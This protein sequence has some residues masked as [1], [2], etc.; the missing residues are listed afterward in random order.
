MIRRPPRSTLFPYTTLFRSK[1][2]QTIDDEYLFGISPTRQLY[3]AWQTTGGGA[4]GTPSFNDVSGTGQIPLNT[5]AHI[6][7]VR[8]GAPLNFSIN[9]VLDASL[10]VV[11]TNPFR[12]G[13]NTL[14]IGGQGRGGVNRFFNGSIDEV[15]I[16]TRALTQAE[17]QND[18][19]S[20]IGVTPPPSDTTPPTVSITAPVTGAIVSGGVTVSANATDNVGV[21]GVQFKLDGANQSAEL[22]CRAYATSWMAAVS[23][24]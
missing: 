6:A 2:S 22:L 15:R 21:V 14:R 5:W 19:N 24:T 12:N 11:D 13:I 20:P 9:G 17:I 23:S 10:S 3:L 1:W 8:S 4:W 16:Y 18:M 7:L